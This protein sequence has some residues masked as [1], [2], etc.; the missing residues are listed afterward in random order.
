MSGQLVVGA[1]AQLDSPEGEKGTIRYVGP[2]VGGKLP[3]YVGIHFD[4]KRPRGHDGSVKGNRYFQCPNGYG[5]Y[6]HPKRVLVGIPLTAA[7]DIRYGGVADPDEKRIQAYYKRQKAKNE[8]E[9]VTETVAT[10]EKVGVDFKLVG[11]AEISQRLKQYSKL[12]QIGLESMR[13]SISGDTNLLKELSHVKSLS[14]DNNLLSD[15]K[16]VAS[17]VNS[18]E[19]EELHL[20]NNA[21]SALTAKQEKE[22]FSE[23]K[24]LKYLRVLVLHNIPG[25]L[26][27][28]RVLGEGGGL[29]VLEEIHL[30]RN[31]IE[32]I[33]KSVLTPKAF[34]MLRLVNLEFN[35][36]AN[37]T[38]IQPLSLLPK[39]ETLLLGHNMLQ[40]IP[41]LKSGFPSLTTLYMQDN[42]IGK[43]GLDTALDTISHLDECKGLTNIR[44]Q[45]NRPLET[46]FSGESNLRL[47]L[48]ARIPKLSVLGLSNIRKKE[49]E[50]AERYY[51][52]WSRKRNLD[53]KVP[54]SEIPYYSL[55]TSRHGA[56]PDAK[57][58]P[59]TTKLS[60]NLLHLNFSCDEKTKKV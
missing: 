46:L 33:S 10:G 5:A 11:E 34:P 15:W 13:I 14:L 1:R 54:I 7:L 45:R 31:K 55:Y 21:L 25:I 52:Q 28:L 18:F 44:L 43:E 60:K 9:D 4:L 59:E 8:S 27:I 42:I 23:A 26:E 3:V 39:L 48:I 6:V 41:S 29:E 22:F 50:N 20:S 53:T 40:S 17:V 37:F 51:I 49:R 58:G 2:V 57:K 32:S 24:S 19:L 30:G 16:Q 35:G 12:K 36:I 47:F 38:Q 56:I